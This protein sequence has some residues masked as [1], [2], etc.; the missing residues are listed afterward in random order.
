MFRSLLYVPASSERFIARAHQR[1][2]DAI[3]LDLE[4]SVAPNQKEAARAGLA[5][6]VAAVSR[7]GAKVFVRINS[8][9][10][11][12]YADAEAACRAG[13]FGLFVSKCNSSEQL[14]RLTAHLVDAER[15]SDRTEATV[16]VPMLEDPGAVLDARQIVSGHAR[17]FGLIVGAEDIATAMGAEPTREAL[18]LPRLLTHLAAKAIGAYSFGLLHSIADFTNEAAI[19]AAAKEARELGFDG[20][21]CVHPNIVRILNTA[22]SPSEAQIDQARR[23]ID[24]YEA[25]LAGGSGACLFE[26]KMIDAPIVER[27]RTMIARHEGRSERS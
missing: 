20:A 10:E 21:T 15:R 17:V 18:R 24:A 5:A 19:E 4:D 2:A 3:I 23:M 14:A 8:E 25:T 6:A 11:R 9:E 12:R 26:G 1:D 27:A 16:L 22:F 13:A 7:N